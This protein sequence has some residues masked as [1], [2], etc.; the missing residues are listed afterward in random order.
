MYNIETETQKELEEIDAW[1]NDIDALNKK[2]HQWA[3]TLLSPP[4]PPPP[5]LGV[6]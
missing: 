6:I 1:Q 2:D 4:P 3:K 5:P